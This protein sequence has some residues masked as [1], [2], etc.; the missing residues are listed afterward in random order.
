[1]ANI[2]DAP[3]IRE[4][5]LYGVPDGSTPICPVCGKEA[6]LA[7][8]DHHGDVIGCDNCLHVGD[9]CDDMRFFPDESGDNDGSW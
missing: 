1:M 9:P 3:W 6:E 5:E 2:D 7:Y 4:T 8:Y